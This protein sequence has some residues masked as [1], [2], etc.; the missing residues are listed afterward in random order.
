MAAKVAH[1]PSSIMF[2]LKAETEVDHRQIEQAIN[3]P[4]AA[5]SLGSY[6]A[7]LQ[8]F[9]GFYAPFEDRLKA[10]D[11][12]LPGIDLTPR[13][14]C[15]WL[16]QD[17]E[18]LGLGSADNV[19]FC[20]DLPDLST[21]SSIW[22]SMYVLEGSTLGGQIISRIIEKNLGITSEAGARFFHGYG[23]RTGEMWTEF[24][25]ALTAY[26][27]NLASQEAIIVAA[28]E[29]FRKLQLWLERPFVDN[30]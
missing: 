25:S 6:G 28:Q 22:G 13:F 14:K 8:R 1:G 3:L 27:N 19:P 26:A 17:L 11:W 7:L 30:E 29:T 23:A 10:N 5:T 20:K 4:V 21:A 18:S 12:S 9:Y 2:R 24:G 16:A 15:P